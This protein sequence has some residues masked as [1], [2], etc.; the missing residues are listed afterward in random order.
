MRPIPLSMKSEILR[1]YL[2][3]DSI[4]D[5]SKL[6]NVSVGTVSSIATEETTKDG[7]Y[8][9]IREVTKIFKDNNLEISDVISGIR[10]KNKVKEVGLTIPFFEDFLE[11]TNTESFR[12]GMD[13]EKFLGI[14]KRILHFEKIFKRKIEDVPDF[15]HNAMKE[16]SKLATDILKARQKLSQLYDEYSVKKSDVEAYL[17]DKSLFMKA[18]L[19]GIALPTHY[20]WVVISD[21]PFKKAS[22]IAKIKIE[23]KILYKK[24]NRIYKEPH[25]HIDILKQIMNSSND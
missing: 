3:G 23:P 9:V 2:Q 17:K 4:P 13:H 19:V 11:F 15:L 1:K 10:L 16:Y 12:I 22:R 14:V 8:L 20:D 18:K 5:I 7:Y 24:L 6:F 21:T 25:K